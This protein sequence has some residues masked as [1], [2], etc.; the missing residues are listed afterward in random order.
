[1][2]VTWHFDQTEISWNALSELY[3]I[4]PLG[5][6]LPDHLKMVFSNSRFKCFVYHETCW[7]A[8]EENWRMAK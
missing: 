8:P 6:K 7:S 4:A 2:D 3:K 1:M 5:T